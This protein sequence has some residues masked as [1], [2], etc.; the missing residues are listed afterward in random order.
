MITNET[1]V[2]APPATV[3]DL[4]VDVERWPELSPGTM[5]SL[6][7]L[8][9]GPLVVGS[10]VR[11]RQPAQPARIWTVTVVD[12]ERRFEWETRVAGSR[13]TAGHRLAP[14]AA[15]GCRNVLEVRLEGRGAGLLERLVRRS[16]AAAIAAE[17][18]GFRRAA[19]AAVGAH[20]PEGSDR[21]GGAGA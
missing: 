11:V 18:D 1:E 9:P 8:D 5:R 6:E 14:T 12:P 16:I 17:N 10:R 3:W 7:R 2:A 21:A 19:E 13:M 15:G 20:R 4:T